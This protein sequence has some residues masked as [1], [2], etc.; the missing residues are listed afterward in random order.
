M[1][2]FLELIKL[3]K[4]ITAILGVILVATGLIAVQKTRA[5]LA[6][7]TTKYETAQ[8]K[9]QK[10]IQTVSASG[11]VEAVSRA[12]V[13]FQTSGK[14]AWVGVQEGDWVKQWQVIAQLD[15]YELQRKLLKELRDYSKER[16]DFEEEYRVTYL[17]RTPQSALTDTVK[18]I[19]EKNQWDLDKAVADVEVA[20]QALKLA[21]LV[22]PI[23]GLVVDI[24]APVAG[25]NITP[26]TAEF[27]IVNPRQMRFVA[28]VD[29]LDVGKIQIDQSVTIFLDAYPDQEFNGEVQ[30]IAFVSTATRGGGTAFQV[31]INLD[32]NSDQRF[33]DGMNGDCEIIIAQKEITLT[34]P[35][36][37]IKQKKGQKYVQIISGR[38]IQD[39]LVE[40]GIE[41]NSRIEIL[42]GVEEGQAVI[43]GEKTKAARKK[44]NAS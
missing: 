6:P 36:K 4:I 26:A 19:L 31:E 25:V 35:F 39:I 10:L 44:D 1:K 7:L 9:K 24:E 38:K 13:K 15:K 17:G 5:A 34:V 3:H 12:T 37:A 22:S 30:K 27:L 2:K 8:V 32:D 43:T 41:S 28:D 18:R 11:K 42:S 16:N 21:A 20:H 40:I 29:E 33:K 23:E 14:L